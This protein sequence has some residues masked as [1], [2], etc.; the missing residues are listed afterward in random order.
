MKVAVEFCSLF[1]LADGYE[2]ENKGAGRFRPSYSH[3]LPGLELRNST[4]LEKR[5]KRFKHKERRKAG[6]TSSWR[7][8]PCGGV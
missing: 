4:A 5:L 7:F 8:D 3:I 6:I 2:R 1:V